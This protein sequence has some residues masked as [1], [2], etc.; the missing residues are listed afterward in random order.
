MSDDQ[1]EDQARENFIKFKVDKP[2]RMFV[3]Q[4]EGETVQKISKEEIKGF[5]DGDWVVVMHGEDWLWFFEELLKRQVT[6]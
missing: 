6:E 5:K 2:F 3:G 4:I 1:R